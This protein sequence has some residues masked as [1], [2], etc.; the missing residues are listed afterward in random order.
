MPKERNSLVF[1]TADTHLTGGRDD[2]SVEVFLSF[3]KMVQNRS[4][5]LYILGDLF[6]FWANTRR[7]YKRHKQVLEA[8]GRLAETGRVGFLIG[9][10]DFLLR[11][12]ILN[13]YGVELLTESYELLLGKQRLFL[14]HGDIFC[15]QDKDYQ[16]YKRRMWRVMRFID[17]FTPGFL[18]DYLAK[19]FRKKSMER[20]KRCDP[21]KLALSDSS[22]MEQFQRGFETI[23]CGHIHREEIRKMGE[24]KKLVI[25]PAWNGQGGYAL[26]EEGEISL[27]RWPKE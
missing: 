10:R 19:R 23:I 7:V 12:K 25:L 2:P 8:L 20:I 5:D 24:G 13:R 27:A 14:T 1:F 16:R 26:W 11:K 6:A 21:E 9:N 22:L 17:R 4:G 18:S 15:K 3:L